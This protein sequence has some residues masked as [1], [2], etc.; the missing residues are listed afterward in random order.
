M[1][2]KEKIKEY[3]LLLQK[4]IDN[5]SIL[6]IFRTVCGQEEDLCGFV[7]GM[8]KNFLLL[9]V[10]NDFM[11]D[12]YAII[13]KGDYDSIRHRRYERTQKKI[14][15]SEGV[16]TAS[17]GLDKTLPLAKW[18]D[19]FKAL[20]KYNFHVIIE[21]VN[22]DYLDFWIGEIKKVTDKSVSIHNYNANGELNEKPTSIK[23]DTISVIKFGDR[24]STVF[25]KYL[26]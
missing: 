7:L 8:S 23:F 17:Y 11:V 12:G 3:D 20:K 1:T 10:T 24:Y 15:K 9:Q 21:N 2:K 14:L 16:F 22:K 18:E 13:K 4:S 5:K 26:K 6:K 25:R 19:I